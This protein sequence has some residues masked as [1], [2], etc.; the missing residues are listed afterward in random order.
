MVDHL[1]DI[2]MRNTI[3]VL[4]MAVG[5]FLLPT[6]VAAHES[7]GGMEY[8]YFCCA[9]NDCQEIPDKSVK[10]TPDGYLITLTTHDHKLVQETTTWLVPY[11]DDR[12]RPKKSTDHKYHVCLYPTPKDLKCLYVPPAH[13]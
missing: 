8:E 9:R 10:I 13:G 1:K 6:L 12:V 11:T 3:R 4:L 7:H 5:L 2:I